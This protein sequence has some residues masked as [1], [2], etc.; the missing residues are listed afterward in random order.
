MLI[1]GAFQNSLT[2]KI[3]LLWQHDANEPIGNII[4]VYEDDFGLYIVAC[5]LL[6]IQKAKEVYV[7]L[8][9]GTIDS[10]SIGYIPIQHEIDR[11]TGARILKQVEL[12]EVSLV[13]FPANP[14]AQVIN[15]KDQNQELI[16]SIE[17]AQNILCASSNKDILP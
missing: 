17:R 3:K 7:M 4:D 14:I 11:V 16:N 8:K 15:V 1:K 13:T 6:A 9:A 12:L 5:L 2:S 10:L